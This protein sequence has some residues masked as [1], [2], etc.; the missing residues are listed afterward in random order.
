MPSLPAAPIL[1]GLPVPACPA[2][3][4]SAPSPSCPPDTLSSSIIVRLGCLFLDYKAEPAFCAM[5]TAIKLGQ[6]VAKGA[7]LGVFY[8]EPCRPEPL[9]SD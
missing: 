6:K 8:G 7:L 3:L 5:Y 4:Q 1:N 9:T 2:R